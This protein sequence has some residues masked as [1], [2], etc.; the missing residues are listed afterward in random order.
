MTVTRRSLLIGAALL[1]ALPAAAQDRRAGDLVIERP[2]SRAAGA[3]AT[4]G[5]FLTIR[6]TGAAPDRLLSASSPIARR[7]ELHT[8]S[9]DGGVMRMRPVETIPVPAG[10]TVQLAPGGLHIMM[11]GLTQPLVQGGRAPL[12]LRFE[13]GGE[14]QVEL[15]V[16]AA[17]AR[18]PQHAH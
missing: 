12:T 5:G 9:M 16:E 14:V 15:V 2:W 17:G 3:N 6:N 8:M 13:R 10:G 7:V 4:G 18:A 11:I 1:A